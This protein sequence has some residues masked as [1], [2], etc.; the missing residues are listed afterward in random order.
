MQGLKGLLKDLKQQSK[1]TEQKE[2][3]WV[4]RGDLL[5]EKQAAMEEE[6]QLE[7]EERMQRQAKK[8]E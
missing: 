7:E 5:Q 4:R 3:K 2:S 8:K 1:R 6:E